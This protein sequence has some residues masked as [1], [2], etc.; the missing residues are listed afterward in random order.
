MLRFLLIDIGPLR[1]HRN[2][3]FLFLGQMVSLFGSMVTLVAIPYQVYQL[4]HSSFAV[5]MLGMAEL[6]P[7]LVTAF[8]GGAL[9]DAVDRR[10]IILGAELGLAIASVALIAN[11]FSP[12]PRVWALYVIAAVMSALNGLHRPS[13]EAM[14][15]RMVEPSELPAVSALSSLRGTI[16]MIGGPT[17]AGV[18]IATW[19]VRAAYV[20][21]LITFLFSLGMLAMIPGVPL[22]KD[23]DRP[24]LKSVLAGL[25]Y[26]RSRQELLGTYIVDIVAMTFGMPTALFPAMSNEL[27]GPRVLGWLYAAPS[28]GAFLATLSSGWTARV[29]RH[30]M[31]ILIAAA[32]WGLAVTAFGFMSNLWAALAFL[33]IAGAADMVSALFRM[34]LW[35]ET[36]PD[37]M[38][39]RLAGV[40]MISYST[41][42]LLGHVESGIVA[43]AMSVRFSVISG[44][45]L[46][47][48]GVGLCT[49]LL[50]KFRRYEASKRESPAAAPD[51]ADNEPPDQP[52]TPA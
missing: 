34:T 16:G 23:P 32:V 1:R 21:D 31:A 9:A 15:P 11:S 47:V 28:I 5:G 22:P 8:I 3:R 6:I 29:R 50:P 36:I 48:L 30:G 14:T 37:R 13:L 27:G 40:E 39:G 41:G 12:E 51:N 52:Q 24:S 18:L 42:P 17:V 10:R 7:L 20:L 25:K 2:F 46:C 45:L 33:A 49:I 35:N 26:A 4:T 43:A 44:G 38:R 19:G